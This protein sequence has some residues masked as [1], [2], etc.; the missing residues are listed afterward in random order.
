MK[1]NFSM[2]YGQVFKFINRPAKI[3]L[4]VLIR[5]INSQ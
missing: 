5:T 2:K 3:F 1:G 4:Q